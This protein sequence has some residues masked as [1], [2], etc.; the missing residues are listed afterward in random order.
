MDFA[1]PA[2]VKTLNRALLKAH[3]GV[4]HWDIPAGFLCPPVPSRADYLYHVADL[5][6][7]DAGAKPDGKTVRALDIGAGAN[8][9][10]P[11]LGASAFGWR[12]VATDVDPASVKWSEKLVAS[13][14]ALTGKIDCRLQCERRAI[15][16]GVVRD[17]ERFTV[18]VCNPPFHGSAEE[19]AAGTLRKLKNLG[20]GVKPKDAVLNFGGR[21]NELWCEGG[22]AGFIQRMIRESAERPGLCVWF[23]TLVSKKATLPTVER[24]LRRAKAVAVRTLTMFAGQKQTRVAAWTFLSPEERKARLTEKLD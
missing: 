12:F 3:Y 10:Y 24:E 23:T 15:F 13:N 4:G 17:G 2:V 19:A 5:L 1:D 18:S 20:G 22:E 21:A 16:H 6:A 7:V 9:I 8:C 14:R 11:I